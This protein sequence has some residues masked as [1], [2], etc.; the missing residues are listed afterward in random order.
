MDVMGWEVCLRSEDWVDGELAVYV[1]PDYVVPD[2]ELFAWLKSDSNNWNRIRTRR[3][4][5]RYSHGVLVP[6]PVGLVEGDEAM[7]VL[8]IERYEPPLPASAGGDNEPGPP[9][10]YPKYDV[11][12]YQRYR[13]IL[14]PGEEVVVTE[15]IHGANARYVFTADRIWAGSRTNWKA[16]DDKNLWWQGLGQNPWI[17]AWCRAHPGLVLYGEVF[18]QVQNLK[19]DTKPGQVKFL[20]FDILKHDEWMDWDEAASMGAR[21]VP[22]LFRGPFNESACIEL[23]CGDSSIA[24]NMREGV[25]IKP[26]HERRDAEAGRVQ[27]KI[28]SPRYLE[29]G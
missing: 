4:R 16:Q 27:L 18:G 11:E 3:F 8:G 26:V 7:T 12:S 24:K 6:A 1:P 22:L 28:V 14:V 21:W 17:E 10:F 19:Y 23:A 13:S 20:A 29:K 25:V 15:K 2:T 9:G 5:G